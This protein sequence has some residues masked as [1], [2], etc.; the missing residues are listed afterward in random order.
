M[1]RRRRKQTTVRLDDA[2]GESET[3]REREWKQGEVEEVEN[4]RRS[5]KKSVI[6]KKE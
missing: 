1:L 2:R 4:C 3:V 6:R 5:E